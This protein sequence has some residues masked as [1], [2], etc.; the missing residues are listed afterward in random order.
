MGTVKRKRTARYDYLR[1]HQGHV[2][3]E[4][5]C[6]ACSEPPFTFAS[7][8]SQLAC[9]TIIGSSPAL[10][11]QPDFLRLSVLLAEVAIHMACIPNAAPEP[12]AIPREH[13]QVCITDLYILD[14][15]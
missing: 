7:T 5:D 3:F 13:L 11:V 6:Y 9:Y 14:L 10:P 1:Q 2:L 4:V 15:N 8:T 12:D